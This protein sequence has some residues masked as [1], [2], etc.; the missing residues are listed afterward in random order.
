MIVSFFKM[1]TGAIGECIFFSS[2]V[3]RNRPPR[4]FFWVSSDVRV[5]ESER[6]HASA[7]D[8]SY[9]D[10]YLGQWEDYL[11]MMEPLISRIPFL[12]GDGNHESGPPPCFPAQLGPD[13]IPYLIHT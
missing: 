2:T 10:G 12:Y 9:A 11:D 7:G 3:L 13:A 5:F 6:R 4:F 1:I 8:I